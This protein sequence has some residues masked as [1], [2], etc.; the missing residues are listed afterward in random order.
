M[1]LDEDINHNVRQCPIYDSVDIV[2]LEVLKANCFMNALKANWDIYSAVKMFSPKSM[3]EALKL[4]LR[5]EI[6][7][8]MRYDRARPV[9]ST[10]L[11]NEDIDVA[12]EIKAMRQAIKELT[13]VMWTTNPNVNYRP[14]NGGQ[15]RNVARGNQGNGQ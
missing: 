8:T 11:Q 15:N 12:Q 1:D 4:A 13:D 7:G 5:L 14:R 6:E 9:R 2:Q 10:S 3:D